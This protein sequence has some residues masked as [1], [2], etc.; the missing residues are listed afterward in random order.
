MNI[1]VVRHGQTDWNKNDL[2]Q[3]RTDVELN[4]TGLKQCMETAEKLKNINIDLIYASPLKR[5][6]KTAEAINEKRE[7]KINLDDRLIERG[8]GNYEGQKKVKF[9]NY[10]DYDLNYSDNKVEPIKELFKRAYL[11]LHEL[12]TKYKE[13][14]I[15]ILIVTHNGANLAISSILNGFIPENIFDNNMLPC[16]IK[17]FSN[18]NLDKW[19]N[20]YEEY[21]N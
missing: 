5:T 18:V 21:K 13:K 11:F 6:I 9:K 20:S 7:K 1:I 16:E 19:R 15:N 3:G 12:E 14:D 2:L 4:E 8:F 17:I 10:W